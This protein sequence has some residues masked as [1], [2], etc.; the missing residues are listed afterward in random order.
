MR[1]LRSGDFFF[2]SSKYREG[3][4][5]RRLPDAVLKLPWISFSFS[6]RHLIW[7]FSKYKLTRS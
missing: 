1:N 7:E 6:S 4:Y 3:G 5:D 2:S